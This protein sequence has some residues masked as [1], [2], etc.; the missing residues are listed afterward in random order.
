MPGAKRRPRKSTASTRCRKLKG[1]TRTPRTRMSKLYERLHDLPGLYVKADT[2]SPAASCRAI[3]RPR[4]GRCRRRRTTTFSHHCTSQRH[5][6]PQYLICSRTRTFKVAIPA[7]NVGVTP[8][9]VRRQCTTRRS[10][11]GARRVTPGG[12]GTAEELGKR[13][14]ESC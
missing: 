3:H 14:T 10:S 4:R 7:R 9:T 6:T 8:S 1:T 13:T 5:T 12:H 11:K 2:N